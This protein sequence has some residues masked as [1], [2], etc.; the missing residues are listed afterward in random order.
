MPIV[1]NM[2]NAVAY[3]RDFRDNE[4]RECSISGMR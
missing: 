4:G 2:G 3:H 1:E